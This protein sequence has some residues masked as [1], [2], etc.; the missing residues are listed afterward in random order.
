MQIKLFKSAALS[1]VL[2][3]LAPTTQITAAC[4]SCSIVSP[5]YE[6]RHD[7]LSELRFDGLNALCGS[8]VEC[9][10]AVT[11]TAEQYLQKQGILWTWSTYDGAEWEETVEGSMISISEIKSGLTS[12]KYRLKTIFTLTD[13]V[14]R[15]ETIK[16]CSE[17]VTVD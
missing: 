9:N 12:G 5:L 8:R 7:A 15:T 13:Q 10:Y 3:C 16:V 6:I 14:G 11:V 4:E 2:L 17:E 1:A